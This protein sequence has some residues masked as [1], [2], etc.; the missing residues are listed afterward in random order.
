MKKLNFKKLLALG[1]AAVTA[2]ASLTACSSSK[3]FRTLD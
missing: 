3:G 1:L 2:V